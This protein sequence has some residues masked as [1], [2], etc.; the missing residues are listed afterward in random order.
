MFFK[1]G[2]R[3]VVCQPFSH[4]SHNIVFPSGFRHFWQVSLILQSIVSNSTIRSARA[5][6][7]LLGCSTL[8]ST[9]SQITFKIMNFRLDIRVRP[10]FFDQVGHETIYA[11]SGSRYFFTKSCHRQTYQNYEQPPRT[12]QNS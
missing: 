4:L 3:Q 11:S 7:S 10:R 12:S 8:M 2:F 9:S 1:G 6:G 5:M